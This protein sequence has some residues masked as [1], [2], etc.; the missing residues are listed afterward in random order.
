MGF[1]DFSVRSIEGKE[2]PLSRFSGK[3][4][5]V[6]NTASEC[7]LT[8]QYD[9]LEKLYTKYRG[10]GFEVLGFPSNDFGAQEPGTDLQIQQFCSTRFGVEFPMFTK[11]PVKGSSKQPVYKYL[12]E[13]SPF[14][15]EITWNFEKFL[16][17]AKGE[18][19]ARFAPKTEPTAP[20]VVT[21]IE[22]LLN[23]Q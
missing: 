3:V 23:T 7:G 13:E 18:V 15:G 20:E 4:S 8:P 19:V 6:V 11:G 16:V 10:K 5:L 17:N 14:P 2:L 9:G 1:Y 22:K 21:A 12:T